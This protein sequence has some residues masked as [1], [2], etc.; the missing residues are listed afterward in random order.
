MLNVLAHQQMDNQS[1]NIDCIPNQ[2][3]RC[4]CDIF[5]YNPH[6]YP[7]I[8]PH[9]YPHQLIPCYGL[10]GYVHH[11]AEQWSQFRQS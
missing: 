5:L 7:Q 3:A 10:I 11:N 8:H 1:S 6:R 2:C 9:I 4:F